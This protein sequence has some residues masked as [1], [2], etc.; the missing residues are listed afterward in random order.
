MASRYPYFTEEHEMF[1]DTVRE[2]VNRELVP[3][4]EEWDKA[5]EFPRELFL[6]MGE[7]GFLGLPYPEE[8]GGSNL[9]Y[10]F[11]V[12]LAEELAQCGL[13]GV[14][15]SILVHSYMG[16]G[17]L[18]LIGSEEVKR[19]YLAAAIR[20]EMIGALGITEAGA[21]S[22]VAGMQ[23]T[24][25]RDGDDYVINGTKMFITNAT[26]ADF[27]ALVAKTDSA[28]GHS[29][30]SMFV[31]PTDLPGFSVSRKLDKIGNRV[32]DTAELVFEDYRVPASNLL[33][34]EGQGFA[35]AMMN[36]QGE[37]LIAAVACVAGAQQVLDMTLEY[38][39][40]RIQFGR[41]IAKFQA[42]RHKFADMA[43]ELEAARQLAY[44][45]AFLIDNGI[46]C[47]KEVS[48]AKLFCCE[49]AFQIMDRCLQL[50]GGYGYM[51][52]Y[53]VSRAWRDVRVNTIAGGTSDVMKEI[54]GRSLGC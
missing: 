23:T 12:V 54:I 1:R 51:T 7:L 16:A 30:I 22:D 35:A 40:Q 29:G 47:V 8:Y 41:P 37:R 44:H 5:E 18:H 39:Q 31:A 50:H 28:A 3:H 38:A 49:T 46:E 27:I 10:F 53:P 33:G 11:S 52:E 45:A 4:V 14:A 17:P 34:E 9:D 42:T 15:Q 36:F 13:A 20:G 32:S 21:G 6:R 48:M 2:F 25:V 24:A 19:K 43:T 26:R